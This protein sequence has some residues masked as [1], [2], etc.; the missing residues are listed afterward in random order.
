MRKLDFL[1]LIKENIDELQKEEKQQTVA[2]LRLRVQFLRLLK[3]QEVDSIKAAAKVVGITAKR[4]Y[5]WRSLYRRQ[6][7][8]EYLR[9]N[10]KPR[11]PRLSEEQ[12]AKLV[13]RA[14]TENGFASQAEAQ[15][16]LA[17]EFQLSYTQAGVSLLFGRLKIKAK[18]P[19]PANQGADEQEQTEYKKTFSGE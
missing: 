17:D 19:R 4:G 10:Y 15:K 6:K 8:S 12:Q 2:R 11:R 1:A 3:T 14:G 18:Q 13:K 9:L 5:Q 7:F 16:Y